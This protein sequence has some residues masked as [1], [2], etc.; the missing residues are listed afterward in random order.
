MK[1]VSIIINCL[2]G[3]KYLESA[4]DSAY[5]QT[6][7]NWEIIFWDNASTDNSSKIAKSYDD[8]LKYYRGEEILPL[9]AAR[10][11]AVKRAKG[12][13]IAFLDSDDLWKKNKLYKQIPLF[14]DEDVGLVH[15]DNSYMKDGKIRGKSTFFK[16]KPPSGYVFR[17]LLK[18]Y[19]LGM[20]NTIIRKVVLD[21]VGLFNETFTVCEEK[22]LFLRIAKEYK[23]EF[24]DEVLDIAR[25]HSEQ[26]TALNF[27]LF[28][29]ENEKIING[30]LNS[31]QS[32]A[33]EYKAE[34]IHFMSK[35][36]FQKS[37]NYWRIGDSKKARKEL[38]KIENSLK[39]KLFYILTYFPRSIY[40]KVI[41]YYFT[42]RH[43]FW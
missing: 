5:R 3:E 27:E 1:L 38:N 4:I 8:R 40:S 32:F 33:E 17:D 7:K 35:L 2:N 13:F 18:N 39:N 34:I 14:K 41:Q 26:T 43:Y 12:E 42:I 6:Y 10:N 25:M 19:F 30:Y 21:E 28:F 29:E 36:S 20:D 24:V 16:W 31:D 11:E 22:D 23:V 9:G 37:V 15:C